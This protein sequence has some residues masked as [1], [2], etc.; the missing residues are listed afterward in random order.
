MWWKSFQ[1]NKLE[2]KLDQH[3]ISAHSEVGTTQAPQ[4]LMLY[5]LI[6]LFGPFSLI[7]KRK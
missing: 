1:Q 6:S 7:W 3:P 5:D 2:Q 4:R